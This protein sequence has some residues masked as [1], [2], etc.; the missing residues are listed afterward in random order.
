MKRNRV[1]TLSGGPPA[2]RKEFVVPLNET[3][4]ERKR[5]LGMAEYR[6]QRELAAWKRAKK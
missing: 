3:G 4:A 2:P 5:R 6:Y 1:V